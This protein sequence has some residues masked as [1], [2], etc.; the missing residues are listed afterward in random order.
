MTFEGTEEQELEGQ[1]SIRVWEGKERDPME[2]VDLGE[3]TE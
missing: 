1:G 2:G 3:G